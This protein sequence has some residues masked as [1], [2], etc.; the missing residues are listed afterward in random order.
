VSGFWCKT[1]KVRRPQKWCKTVK[2]PCPCS[3]PAQP[4]V[5]NPHLRTGNQRSTP[6]RATPLR[7][8]LH[9]ALLFVGVASSSMQPTT[10]GNDTDHPGHRRHRRSGLHLA[11]HHGERCSGPPA[12]PA[13][14]KSR[15]TCRRRAAPARHTSRPAARRAVVRSRSSTT[16][17]LSS[18]PSL[19]RR[20]RPS[21]PRSTTRRD[22]QHAAR[23]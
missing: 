7:C 2:V 11:S 15:A 8:R 9:H 13:T 16:P 17:W 4:P 12:Y 23:L 3:A 22:G 19:R 6:C 20:L 5:I 18:N 21:S 14:D 1:V 10:F